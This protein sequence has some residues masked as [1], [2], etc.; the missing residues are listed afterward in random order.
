MNW[1]PSVEW[2]DT[3]RLRLIRRIIYRAAAQRSSPFSAIAMILR[4]AGDKAETLE[5]D[6]ATFADY[7]GDKGERNPD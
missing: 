2:T 3:D 4:V 5:H 7:Y 1:E 6:R